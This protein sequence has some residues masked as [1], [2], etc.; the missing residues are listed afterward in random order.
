VRT[1]QHLAPRSADTPPRHAS[2]PRASV[3]AARVSE[4]PLWTFFLEANDSRVRKSNWEMITS[5]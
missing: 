5:S 2:P 4:E 1:A 3:E